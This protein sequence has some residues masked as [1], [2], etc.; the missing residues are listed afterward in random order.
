MTTKFL[1]TLASAALAIETLAGGQQPA[2]TKR[3]LAI[4]AMPART[5]AMVLRNATPV[6]VDFAMLAALQPAER[7]ALTVSP[8]VELAGVVQRIESRGNGRFSVFGRIDDD[9]DGYF[10]LTVEDGVCAAIFDAPRRGEV[11]ELRYLDDGLS[12][13]AR[14]ERRG[15]PECGL[16]PDNAGK[17]AAAAHEKSPF[18]GVD[19]RSY[20]HA[21]LR[22]VCA[23]PGERL[24]VI[25]AYTQ[26]AKA[27]AGGTTAAIQA[28]AQNAVDTANQTYQ[29]SGINPRLFLLFTKQVPYNE[30]ANMID[31]RDALA[32]PNDN[33]MDQ[34]HADRDEFGADVV[35][36]FV[37]QVSSDAGIS[38]CTPN[39][40][41]EGFCV[42]R[43]DQAVSN[44]SFAHEIGHLQGCA[45]DFAN[46]GIGCNET[47]YAYGWRFFGNS[48]QGWRT[49][50]A[51]DNNAG[52]YTRIGKFSS[53]NVFFDG[54]PTGNDNSPCIINE[55]NVR[56]INNT[57]LSRESWRMPK[58]DV[59]VESGAPAPWGGTWRFPLPTVA[60]G[61]ANVYAGTRTPILQPTLN[62]KAGTYNETMTISTPMTIR[63][64]GGAATIGG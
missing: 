34:L 12:Q 33:Q 40:A 58:F 59:W 21:A 16:R 55:N 10:I 43:Q 4:A 26:L 13:I 6:S 50:M 52:D 15:A 51:Y 14:V 27:Q 19:V 46:A 24:D 35:C 1:A 31:D 53:P 36:L 20:P 30:S 61:V 39:G 38:F 11:H 37:G 17:P 22:G 63:S 42:V 2:E 29:A 25:I 7:L 3:P 44:F 45:H 57:A 56:N 60:L 18:D 64:C 49:V 23:D 32:D 41:T 9:P 8:T 28:V 48:G 54:Q 62:V 5:A 47:C